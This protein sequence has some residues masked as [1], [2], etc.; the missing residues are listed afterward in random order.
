MQLK[1]VELANTMNTAQACIASSELSTRIVRLVWNTGTDLSYFNLH[2]IKIFTI[3]TLPYLNAPSL[4]HPLLEVRKSRMMPNA[5]ERKERQA[6]PWFI[7][8]FFNIACLRKRPPEITEC[9]G[10]IMTL[11]NRDLLS[12]LNGLFPSR[13]AIHIYAL[14]L[15]W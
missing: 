3:A 4:Y 14:H 11:K 1:D 8:P 7:S 9:V 2:R 10:G 13:A 12:V 15:V 6:A 5:R